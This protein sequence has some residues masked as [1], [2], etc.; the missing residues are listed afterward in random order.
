MCPIIIPPPSASNVVGIPPDDASG[1]MVVPSD[2]SHSQGSHCGDSSSTQVTRLKIQMDTPHCI[3]PA[4]SQDSTRYPCGPTYRFVALHGTRA[5]PVI[6]CGRLFS[7]TATKPNAFGLYRGV[8]MVF[9]SRMAFAHG[10]IKRYPWKIRISGTC[11]LHMPGPRRRPV[12][13]AARSC[14]TSVAESW[15]AGL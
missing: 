2:V 1:S 10:K 8:G 11:M 12:A 13:V 7:S 14:W 4:C 5:I 15:A 9:V 3:N 6:D